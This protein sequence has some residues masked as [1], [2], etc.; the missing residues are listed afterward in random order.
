ME[1]SNL[2]ELNCSVR[3]Q[4]SRNY[5]VLEKL[6]KGTLWEKKTNNKTKEIK[7]KP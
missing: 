6:N 3:K 7:V 4:T 1:Q 2:K 5:C